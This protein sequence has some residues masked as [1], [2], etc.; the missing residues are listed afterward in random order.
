[1]YE[2]TFAYFLALVFHTNNAATL[3]Q[4]R[5]VGVRRIAVGRLRQ[6]C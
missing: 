2:I 3:P 4:F 6:S 1:M 5:E